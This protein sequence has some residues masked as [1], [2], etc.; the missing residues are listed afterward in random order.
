MIRGIKLAAAALALGLTASVASAAS[1]TFNI[2]D[3]T[4]HSGLGTYTG[5]ID[6]DGAGLLS[7]SLTNTSPAAN[8]GYITGFLFNID[9]NASASYNAIGGDTFQGVTDEPANPYGIF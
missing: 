7:I 1:T 3:G 5:T 6:Y 4:P 2:T 9:G 8:G